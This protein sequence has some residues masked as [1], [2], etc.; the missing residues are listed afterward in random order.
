[1]VLYGSQTGTAEELAGR[2]AKDLV[3][4]GCKPLF[5]DPEDIEP[6]DLSRITGFLDFFKYI[7]IIF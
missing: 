5:M 7:Y 2:L 3:R 4:Y 6:E 1:M